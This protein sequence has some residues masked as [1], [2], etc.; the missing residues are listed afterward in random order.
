MLRTLS[1][2]SL[3]P[4]VFVLSRVGKQLCR[5]YAILRLEGLTSSCIADWQIPPSYKGVPRLFLQPKNASVFA[6]E[7][8]Q[9]LPQSAIFAAAFCGFVR[10]RLS[11]HAH[12]LGSL[13]CAGDGWEITR[14]LT[15]TSKHHNFWKHTVHICLYRK[16]IIW[17]K[18]IPCFVSRL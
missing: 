7:W 16:I 10:R 15:V 13:L 4:L 11:T 14:A 2:F 1:C 8:W 17:L 12:S 5:T 6:A 9:F 3:W 18:E